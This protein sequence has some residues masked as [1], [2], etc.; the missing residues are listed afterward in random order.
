MQ[1][2]FPR[3]FNSIATI[4]NHDNANLAGQNLDQ[5]V[6]QYTNRG[7]VDCLITVDPIGGRLTMHLEEPLAANI[8]VPYV[9][10]VIGANGVSYVPSG[11]LYKVGVAIPI[12]DAF[13]QLTHFKYSLIAG[14]R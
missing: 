1:Y 11:I 7:E 13:G 8:D 14:R 4:L 2:K 9:S 12:L 6:P 10:N 3:R 5:Y